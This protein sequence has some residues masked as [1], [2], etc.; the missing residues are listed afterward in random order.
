MNLDQAHATLLKACSQITTT[1]RWLAML[2]LAT[3]FHRYSPMN[4]MLLWS[5]GATGM[6]NSYKRWQQIPDVDGDPCQVRK[7][8]KALR[9][10]AP[11]VVKDRTSED[12]DARRTL[13]K[14]VPVF[15]QSQ[16][17]K[18]PA[19]SD[20]ELDGDDPVQL[21]DTLAGLIV[22]EGYTFH[23]TDIHGGAKG[24]TNFVDKTVVVKVGMSAL[25]N[26][27][28]TAHELAHVLM[29]HPDDPNRPASRDLLELE[30]ETV[31]WLVCHHSGLD[32]TEYSTFYLMGWSGGDV[33]QIE[34]TAFRALTHARLIVERAFP[35]TMAEAA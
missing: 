29:H 13:F 15:D 30:A 16:L 34:R 28:T 19:D 32:V 20:F 5:Q 25:Q 31:A 11:M 1:D 21:A 33:E 6:V 26:A 10:Y 3:K 23:F 24:R 7:G 35:V 27:K 18:P 14:L 2:A 4:Q 12:P 9:V 8:E 22:D 17:N